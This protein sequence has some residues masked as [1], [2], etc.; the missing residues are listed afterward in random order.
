M[1]F[2]GDIA[3]QFMRASP[4]YYKPTIWWLVWVSYSIVSK[5][6]LSFFILIAWIRF[7]RLALA[8]K[9]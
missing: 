2:K 8:F 3:Y 9:H 1:P 5:S 4:E 7:N 6:N